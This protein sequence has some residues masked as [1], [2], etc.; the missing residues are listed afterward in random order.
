M[1][2]NLD[3]WL[4]IFLVGMALIAINIKDLIGAVLVLSA[5]SL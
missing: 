5:Y 3:F 1:F 4:L 2:A